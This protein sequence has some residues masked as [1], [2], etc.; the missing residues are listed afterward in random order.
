MA[1]Y[2]WMVSGY[3]VNRELSGM[4]KSVTST[5]CRQHGN[6]EAESGVPRSK[7]LYRHQGRAFSE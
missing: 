2:G 6:L 5:I 7:L 1:A 3:A 4:T